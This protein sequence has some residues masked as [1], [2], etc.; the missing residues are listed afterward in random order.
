M[1]ASGQP[2]HAEA[3]SKSLGHGAC[4]APL[5]FM[6]AGSTPLRSFSSEIADVVAVLGVGEVAGVGAAVLADGPEIKVR[7]LNCVSWRG[8]RV[9]RWPAI[10]VIITPWV[11]DGDAVIVGQ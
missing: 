2:C 8:V 1:A 6:A 9:C 3:T 7:I 11:F 4:K 10:P 5:R